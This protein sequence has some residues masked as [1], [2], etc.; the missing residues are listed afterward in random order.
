MSLKSILIAAATLTFVAGAASAHPHI[1]SAAPAQDASVT[2]PPKAV[3]IK[4]N[5]AP[6]ATFSAI[7]VKDS[8][9]KAV[10]TGKTAIDKTDKTVLTA[11]IGQSLPP[12]AYTV[13]WKAAGSD[14]HKVSGS[15]KFTV[16]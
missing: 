2:P 8:A 3:R 1:I 5:E 11:D 13:E 14:T 7:V 9:G 16:R 15:Y 6:N 12:G 10:K 4:F